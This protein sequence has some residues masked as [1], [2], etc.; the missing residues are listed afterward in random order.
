MRHE[1]RRADARRD[2]LDEEEE[3]GHGEG[4]EERGVAAAGDDDRAGDE[5]GEIMTVGHTDN[6]ERPG[7][8]RL[9]AKAAVRRR[10]NSG[11][12]ER[13]RI[14]RRRV[15]TEVLLRNALW[16]SDATDAGDSIAVVGT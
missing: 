8:R 11:L 7:V 15:D 1:V 16:S 12:R 4:K 10:A 13:S 2:E 14:E 9:L 5:E 6:P 3:E